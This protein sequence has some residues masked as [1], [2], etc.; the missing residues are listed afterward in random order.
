MLLRG[1]RRR[2]SRAVTS[3]STESMPVCIVLHSYM[4]ICVA[5]SV[6]V[7]HNSLPIIIVYRTRMCSHK[8]VAYV[9]FCVGV[10][11]CVFVVRQ[12]VITFS[13]ISAGGQDFV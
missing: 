1:G 5:H 8:R 10:L 9:L 6:V 4:C 13:L 3:P 11:I 12:V 2:P 7:S